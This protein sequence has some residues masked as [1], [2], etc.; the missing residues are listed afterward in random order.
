MLFAQWRQAGLVAGLVLAFLSTAVHAQTGTV[1]GTVSDSAGGVIPG[2][3]VTLTEYATGVVQRGLAGAHGD[4]RFSE[5]RPGR[6]AV[7]TT[8]EG[9]RPS[10]LDV[11]IPS[12]T[13]AHLAITLE[14]RSYEGLAHVYN[15]PLI[16]ESS[17]AA[18]GLV[19]PGRDLIELP[20]NGRNF[21]RSAR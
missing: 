7:R 2:A 8:V 6:Y 1:A 4:F 11:T 15:E 19:T 18:L 14:V 12:D 9:F 17:H 21:T 20:L 16:I 13:A 10:L 3:E 5:L